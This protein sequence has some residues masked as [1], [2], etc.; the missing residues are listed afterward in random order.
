MFDHPPRVDNAV[1]DRA[2]GRLADVGEMERRKALVF[3]MAIVVVVLAAVTL[4][5]TTAVSAD[6]PTKDPQGITSQVSSSFAAGGSVVR[7]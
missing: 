7:F 3:V 6:D 4:A 1:R 5:I 2:V